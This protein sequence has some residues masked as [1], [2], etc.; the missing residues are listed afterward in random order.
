VANSARQKVYD[1]VKARIEAI[2]AGDSYDT[3]PVIYADMAESF[4]ADS[5][6]AIWVEYGEETP[7]NERFTLSGGGP[8]VLELVINILVRNTTRG[9]VMTTA[10]NAL[11]DVRNALYASHEDYHDDTGAWFRGLDACTTDEGSLSF[12]GMVLF[13]QPAVFAYA[14]GPTW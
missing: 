2:A 8:V 13:S 4:S 1:E 12:D 9:T 14:A 6:V 3:T 11:Q 10:N 7:D 5:E